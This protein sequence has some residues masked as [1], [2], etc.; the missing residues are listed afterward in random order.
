[1]NIL[2][3]SAKSLKEIIKETA[4]LIK[5]GG[6]V[7]FPTDTVYGLLAD[8][9][10]KKAVKKVF[11]I[12]KRKETKAIPVFVK[13]IKMA[14][15][16]AKIDKEQECFLKKVWPGKIT[17]ILKAKKNC[18]LAKEL[19][20]DEKTLGLRKPNHKLVNELL[21][22]INKPLT[23]TSAN[24]SGKPASTKI[25]KVLKQFQKQKAQPD[26][27]IDRGNLPKSRVSTVIILT[28]DKIK[29]LR[30]GDYLK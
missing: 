4:R 23:G 25:K 15:S 3:I 12:K 6:V 11:E 14:K 5:Q 7:I 22:K 8:A 26:L 18:G 30:K 13:D 19:F 10:N 20:G 28:K 24:I 1:M 17:M 9:K 21:E 2:K 27:I 29:I 16:L